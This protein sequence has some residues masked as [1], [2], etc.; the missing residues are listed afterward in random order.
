VGLLSERGNITAENRT[1]V[2]IVKDI[3]KSVDEITAMVKRVD[4][5]TPQVLHLGE[6]SAGGHE[7]HQG[8]RGPVG[9]VLSGTS[10]GKHL[11]GC[12]ASHWFRRQPFDA[13]VSSGGSPIW[14]TSLVALAYHG[15]STSPPTVNAGFRHKTVGRLG[16]T[17][18]DP[19]FR[20]DIGERWEA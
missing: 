4:K 2:L 10:R 5:P 17:S 13:S 15:G 7:L 16:S 19:G 8:P 1:N 14:S 11:S 9:R 18:A 6:D 3:R 20:L 12:R